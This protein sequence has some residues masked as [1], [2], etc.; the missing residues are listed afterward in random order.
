MILAKN[1]G[2]VT[3]KSS[4]FTNKLEYIIGKSTI[5]TGPFSSS[6]TVKLPEDILVGG[7]EHEFYD[8]PF[9]LDVIPVSEDTGE[10]LA[11]W[12]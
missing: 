5:S 4:G 11:D 2:F 10:M 12:I 1:N 6:Q 7:L 8:F 3:A 9:S